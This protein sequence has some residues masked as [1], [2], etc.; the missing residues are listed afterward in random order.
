[1]AVIM[2]QSQL[3]HLSN[4]GEKMYQGIPEQAEV[5]PAAQV[6]ASGQAMNPPAQAPPPAV[7]TSGPNSNPLNLF[8]QVVITFNV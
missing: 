2:L 7:P 3:L 5:P 4:L 6:P 1:M 8:P